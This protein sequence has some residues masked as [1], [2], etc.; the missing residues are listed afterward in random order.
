MALDA[1]HAGQQ[2]DRAQ[3]LMDL[4]QLA[5]DQPSRV[6][7]SQSCVTPEGDARELHVARN[8]GLDDPVERAAEQ[9]EKHRHNGDDD[10]A[11]ANRGCSA[12]AGSRL[13]AQP[14]SRQPLS[15][16][17]ACRGPCQ[18]IDSRNPICPRARASGVSVARS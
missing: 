5:V 7:G 17:T 2:P 8:L 4:A 10:A 9:H 16:H 3:P 11:P 15:R 12:T 18:K 14:V 6:F 1:L 13:V